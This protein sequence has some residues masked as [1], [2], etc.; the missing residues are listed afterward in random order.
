MSDRPFKLVSD[1]EPRGDQPKAIKELVEALKRGDKQ[2]TLLGITGS[3]K[4]YTAACVIEA[5]QRVSGRKV[6]YRF[7]PRR[8]GDA[9]VLVASSE[10]A[11]RELGWRPRFADL[12][13]IVRTAL[14]WREAH[15][16]GYAD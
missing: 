5:V 10:R 3:G 1:Y 16:N 13:E 7:C 15:P 14:F 11:H 12:D 9:A 8:P 2:Q 4:T 6:P